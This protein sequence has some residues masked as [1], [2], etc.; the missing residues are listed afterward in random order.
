MSIKKVCNK[1]RVVADFINC[2]SEKNPNIKIIKVA[3]KNIEI[4]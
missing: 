3:K 1:K 2:K 4:S